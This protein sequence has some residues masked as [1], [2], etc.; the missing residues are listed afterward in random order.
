M[1]YTIYRGNDVVVQNIHPEGTVTTKLMGEETAALS[2]TLPFEITFKLED[3]IQ[4]Y[5]KNF[6]LADTPTIDKKSSREYVYTMSFLSLKYTLRDIQLMFYDENNELTMPATPFMGTAETALD[7]VMLNIARLQPGWTKGVVDE[8]EVKNVEFTE[9]N[10]LEALSKIAETFELEF[11]VDDDKSIHFTERKPVSGYSFEYGKGKGL[12]N[13]N[14]KPLEG[15]SI[16]TRLYVKGSEKNL[17]KNYRNGQQY[18]RMDV[19][20]LEKNTDIYGVKEHTE[21]F[22]VYPKY[23]G[24]VTAVDA[25]DPHRFIDTGIDFDLNA[26][27]QYG[28]TVLMNGVTVK[29]IFQTGQ[30][31]GYTLE[32][33]EA[34]GFNYN[35]K[36]FYLQTNKDEKDMEVPSELLRPAVGDKYIL[37]DLMMPAQYVTNAEAELKT[38]GQEYLDQNCKDRFQYSMGSDRMYFKAQNVNLVLGSTVHFKDPAF[39]LDDDIRVTSLSVDIQDPYEVKFDLNESSAVS[40]IVKSYYEQQSQQNTIINMV[41]YNAEQ[42]RRNYLFAREFHDNVF[43]GEGYF[44][45]ENI[46]PLSIETKMLSLGSRMQQFALPGVDFKLSNN[47]SMMNTAGKLSHQTID[48]DGIREWNIAANSVIGISNNF[49][50]IYIKAQRVGTNANFVVTEAQIKV[51]QD[52]DFYYFEVGYL[53]SVIDGYRKIKTTY[54]FAQLNPSEL[55]IGRVSSPGGNSYLELGETEITLRGKMIFSNGTDV[56]TA[57]TGAQ[58]TADSAATAAANAQTAANNANTAVTNL[59]T[60]VDG[61][62]ADGIISE[63]EAIAIEKYINAVNTEY[64]T[65]DNQ[66]NILYNNSYLAG[67]PK[68]NLASAK[69]AYNTAKNNLLLSINTAIADGKTTTAEKSDVDSK[70]SSYKTALGTLQTR[71]EEANTSIQSYLNNAAATAQTTANSAISQLTDIASDSKLTPSEKQTTQNEWNRIKAEYSQNY[72]V[73]TN[74]AVATTSYTSAYNT[75]NTYITPL[76]SNLTTTSDIVGSTFR[77]N[78]QNYYTQNIAILT[79]IENAKIDNVQVGGR[80]F[81]KNS[82]NFAGLT[83]WTKNGNVVVTNADDYITLSFPANTVSPGIYQ[84]IDLGGYYGDI[85]ISFDAVGTS[86]GWNADLIIGIEGKAVKTG[87]GINDVTTWTRFSFTLNL[88]TATNACAF[89]FYKGNNANSLGI[90]LKNI[91]LEKG[92]KATDWTPA[93]ED[94][95]AATAAA[96][97]TANNAISQLTDIASDSKLSPSEKQ[98]TLNEWNR[99]K[100]EYAQNYAVATNLVV[101]TTSY[102]S[103][104][105]TL[106]TYITP[107]LADLTTTSDIVGA[108]FRTNFQNYYT[109]NVAILTAIENAKIDNVQ[110]GG[111]NLVLNSSN[112]ISMPAPSSNF[113]ETWLSCSTSAVE[114][115]IP[116][117]KDFTI[118]VWY[119]K[120]KT[121]SSS[122]FYSIVLGKGTGD[123]WSLRFYW[124]SFIISEESGLIKATATIKAPIGASILNNNGKIGFIVF[125]YN[126][127]IL[128]KK[129]KL[130]KGNK[131]TDWTPAPEDVDAA[132][133]TNAAAAANALAQAQNAQNT[134]ATIQ[135]ITSFMQ[136]TI[137]NNVVATGTLLVGDVNGANAMVCG[138]TDKS[139]GE[140]IRFAAGKDYA[141]KYKSPF[142]VLDNGLVRFVNPSSG[143][144]VFELGYNQTSG[145]VVFDIYNESG[146]KTATI[147]SQGIMFTGYIPESYETWT[148]RKLT[149]TTDTDRQTEY[150]SNIA[151]S[152]IS[153][154]NYNF[155]LVTNKT[156]YEYQAGYNFESAMNSVYQGKIFAAE[157]K[158]GSFIEDG[159]YA[160]YFTTQITVTTSTQMITL[161]GTIWQIQSGIVVNS[162]AV[163]MSKRANLFTSN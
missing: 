129:I 131:A 28:T 13:I 35:T 51:E 160:L 125:Q 146:V 32:L 112:E 90:S 70:Y 103:A 9:C 119:S 116:V 117:E 71:I 55:S 155:Y 61:A 89:I 26:Y 154:N 161:Y 114:S 118:T 58:S 54:G 142:Q 43:D 134:A 102:T 68:T 33:L 113:N 38:K 5:G 99:I 130:E 149:S 21:T 126:N 12:K 16:V 27:D 97:T 17:P 60:Y 159:Y 40:S 104:Y 124:N 6:Y 121:T 87:F 39:A 2:F 123:S 147:G 52:P 74:L 7:M 46:K 156:G 84:R 127:G 45:M 95:D 63:S 143:Q 122:D 15:A 128:L 120:L 25:A 49:N 20:Y 67:I 73:A 152:L 19:P 138:V 105:N 11:W 145:K 158:L 79:A 47:N 10:C 42:A 81:L 132:I 80:N 153:G 82:K 92:N 98:T 24:T 83:N 162:Q 75:L 18:L 86:S 111:R 108:T 44:D 8:T 135:N 62:F 23:E 41:K 50:Y 72:A 100:A 56:Q 37:V 141:N 110:V 150:L 57:V 144:R 85:T 151:K 133:A 66:Y 91:K 48:P 3:R 65:F 59:N 115:N 101:A 29:V 157:N 1:R 96:Q 140:S 22:D 14:R 64:N 77:T 109:Q 163:T 107:L 139:N 137:D 88:A 94:V 78:F 34:G 4:I 93:P 31:A 136:T 76:L 36:T 148:F 53:S 69:T 30:L 106:N